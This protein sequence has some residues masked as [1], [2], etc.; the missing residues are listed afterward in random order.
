MSNFWRSS[1]CLEIFKK[2][3]LWIICIG[4]AY[5]ILYSSTT[6]AYEYQN[7]NAIK[8]KVIKDIKASINSDDLSRYQ[9]EVQS[10]DNRLRLQACNSELITRSTSTSRFIGRQSVE[11]RCT[12]DKPWKIYLQVNVLAKT[13]VPVLKHAMVSGSVI[14]RNDIELTQINLGTGSKPIIRSVD[15]LL[16]KKVKRHLNA[17]IPILVSQIEAPDMIQR[18]QQVSLEYENNG[19]MVRMSGRSN[20]N[21]A[22]GDWIKVVNLNSGKT[23]EGRVNSSGNVSVQN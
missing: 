21:G 18:G 8:A 23:I 5:G 12:G 1:R 19:L 20:Q 22:E 10:L 13:D 17:G 11:V 16:G 14:S 4:Y 6:E 3:L 7:L 9:I 2:G 15:Q